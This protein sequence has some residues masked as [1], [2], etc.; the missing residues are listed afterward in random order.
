MDAQEII[1]R[2]ARI[3]DRVAD[4]REDTSELRRGVF[5]YNGSP[6]LMTRIDRLEVVERRRTWTIRALFTAILALIAAS[7]SAAFGIR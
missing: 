1:E 7:I 3:E 2:L 5:G 4:V 6:G